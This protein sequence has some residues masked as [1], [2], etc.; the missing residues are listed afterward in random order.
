MA[1]STLRKPPQ[2]PPLFTTNP[3]SITEDAERLLEQSRRIQASVVESVDISTATFA[4]VLLPLA[5]DENNRQKEAHILEFYQHVS[6]N[7][8]LRVASREVEAQGKDFAVETA[9]RE[10]IFKLVEAVFSKNET[11][12][13]ESRQLLEKERRGYI[14]NGLGLP[15]GNKRELFME[16]RKRLGRITIE[17]RKNLTEENGGVWFSR[18]DL[19]GVPEDQLSGFEHGESEKSGQLRVTFKG[20]DVST[21]MRYATNG[22]T[23]RQLLIA[24]ANKTKQNVPLLKEALTLRYEAARLLGYP[25]HAAFRLEEKMIK[26]PETVNSFLETFDRS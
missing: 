3:H 2:A 22:E 26:S 11:L 25:N 5:Q 14:R 8:E 12:D 10:D 18:K 13:P 15:A 4:N 1:A 23:R 16:I 24:N 17:F 7:E 20:P 6:S 21:V 9:M 19:E